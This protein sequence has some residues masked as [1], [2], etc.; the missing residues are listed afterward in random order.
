MKKLLVIIPDQLSQIIAKGEITLNYYNPGNLFD[1]VH[2]L[3]TNND[4]PNKTKLQKMVG[5]AKLHL[6]NL[7][8]PDLL[9]SGLFNVWLLNLWAE[10][11]ITIAKKIKPDLI[12]CHGAY[13]NSF[14]AFRIKKKLNIPYVISLHI[15]P[16][17]NI[18]DKSNIRSR[19]YWYVM[20]KIEK[21]GLTNSDLV[22][23]VY[24]A[25]IPYLRRLGVNKYEVA[26]NILNQNKLRKKINYKLHN[27]VRLI[28]VGRLI[29]EK[30][31]ENIIKAMANIEG[32]QLTIVGLGPLE[33][34]L[35][36]LVKDVGVEKRVIFIPSIENDRLCQKLTEEDIF[37][38]YTQYWEI[39]KAVLEALLT[40]LPVII[41]NRYGE[42]VPELSAD[43]VM[44]VDGNPKSYE[45]ALRE[46]IISSRKRS[47]LGQ[48]AYNI[49]MTQWSPKITEKKYVEIYKRLISRSM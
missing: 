44:K 1:E 47:E 27:P 46:L 42:P 13:L 20:Q 3:M 36:Q 39:S 30:S 48:K 10:P 24:K 40:G 2:V 38:V 4:V 14:L 34:H 19:I 12:R 35:K 29:E 5:I 21:I 23:P 33:R 41:N 32:T 11:A 49:A 31:P 37:V 6:Y 7:P 22:I 18:R 8:E 17:V 25:I 26:Y 9:K 16:D 43:L 15:N 28:S 45:S